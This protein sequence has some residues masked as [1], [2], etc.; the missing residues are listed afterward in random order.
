MIDDFDFIG[1]YQQNALISPRS[2]EYKGLKN[3]NMSV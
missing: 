3:G 1:L 2:T